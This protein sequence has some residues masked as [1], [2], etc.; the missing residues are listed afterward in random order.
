MKEVKM[1]MFEG[2]PHSKRALEMKKELLAA[3]PEYN[4]VPFVTVDEKLHPE[5][6]EKYDYYYVPSFFVGGEKLADGVPTEEA[7]AK[8]F[9][10]AYESK[11]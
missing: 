1:F 11:A 8:V 9:R 7:I 2:C 4:A 5:E 6:A 10:T 3:H